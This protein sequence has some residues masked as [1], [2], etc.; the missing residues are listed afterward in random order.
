[1]SGCKTAATIMNARIAAIANGRFIFHRKQSFFGATVVLFDMQNCALRCARARK[2]VS[3][4]K[5]VESVVLRCAA[6]LCRVV[7]G[8][9]NALK[10]RCSTTELRP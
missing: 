10:G 8:A 6:F 3:E 4:R 5:A 1:M 2:T 7:Q 9:Q